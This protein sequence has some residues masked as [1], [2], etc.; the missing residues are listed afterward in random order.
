MV[1]FFGRKYTQVVFIAKLT[2]ITA[3]ILNVMAP[4]PSVVGKPLFPGHMCY[5]LEY[6]PP[7]KES[8]SSLQA[9]PKAAPLTSENVPLA[10][11]RRLSAKPLVDYESSDEES[12]SEKPSNTMGVDHFSPSPDP[13]EKDDSP[14]HF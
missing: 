2:R 14:F 3:R 4:A 12:D 1:L 13:Q 5:L 11:S 7:G 10:A 9:A 8:F 6:G